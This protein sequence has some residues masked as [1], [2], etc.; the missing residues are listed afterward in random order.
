MKNEK[1][2]CYQECSMFAST[3]LAQPIALKL[4][5]RDWLEDSHARELDN[6]YIRDRSSLAAN[7]CT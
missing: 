6:V 2:Q 3:R 5:E 1:V 7:D 4:V